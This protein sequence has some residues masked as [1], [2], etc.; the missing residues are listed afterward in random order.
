MAEIKFSTGQGNNMN[1]DGKK[2]GR[3]GGII[4][5]IIVAL[6]ILFNCFAIVEEGFRGVKIRLGAIVSDDL[7]PG[8]RFKIPF[9]EEIRTV[10]VR[11]LIFPWQGDA[12]TKDTQTVN[13]L[14]LKVTYQYDTTMLSHLI[15]NVGIENVE[16]R[17]LVPN[18]Q[19]IAKDEIGRVDAEMLVQTRFAVQTRIEEE[20]ARV[21]LPEGI[22]VTAFAIENIAFNA[23]FEAAIE[24]KVIAAQDALRME[25]KTAERAEEARQVVIAAQARADSVEIEATA[26]ARA[27]ELIQEQL[28]K[29]PGYIDYL[30]IIHWNGILPQVIGDGVNPFVVLGAENA[31]PRTAPPASPAPTQ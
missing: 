14:R 5:I 17:F 25:N 29:S 13:D 2:A 24:S 19:K 10:E 8:L 11:N 23:A 27:I 16:A 15:R 21:L 12:Y 26:E 18:V 30:K 28:A 31:Q 9:I 6:I 7:S 3:M 20:L 4:A 22:I 1:I